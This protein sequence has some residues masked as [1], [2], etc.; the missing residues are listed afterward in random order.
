MIWNIYRYL[1]LM[2]FAVDTT[3]GIVL[4]YQLHHHPRILI[5]S[6]V[7]YILHIFPWYVS[8]S[9]YLCIFDTFWPVTCSAV[10]LK[11]MPR[12]SWAT[13]GWLHWLL[14]MQFSQ[15]SYADMSWVPIWN[16]HLFEWGD[17]CLLRV[18]CSHKRSLQPILT[19]GSV[20]LNAL[21][22]LMEKHIRSCR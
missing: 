16:T 1:V 6:T 19:W 22:L 7:F 3:K 15:I 8:D 18:G 9:S 21:K 12:L 14:E 2:M 10:C 17:G 4:S 13:E 11:P 5:I 20:E